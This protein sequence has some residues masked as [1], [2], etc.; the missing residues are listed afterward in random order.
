MY[1]HSSDE[2]HIPPAGRASSRPTTPSS[3]S[4]ET[5]PSQTY[6]YPKPNPKALCTTLLDKDSYVPVYVQKTVKD[7]IS[8]TEPNSDQIAHIAD[9]QPDVNNSSNSTDSTVN[10]KSEK[11]FTETS[12][13]KNEDNDDNDQSDCIENDDDDDNDDNDDDDDDEKSFEYTY[14]D[15]DEAL[16]SKSDDG[17]DAKTPTNDTN[18][19]VSESHYM[20]MTPKKSI[21]SMSESNIFASSKL[22]MTDNDNAYVEM[23]FHSSMLAHDSKSSYELVC[24]GK[25]SNHCRTESEP[26]YMELSH[27]KNSTLSLNTEE[28]IANPKQ[29][30]KVGNKK[31][32]DKKNDSANTDNLPD[33]LKLTKNVTLS[34]SSDTEDENP[35][36]MYNV[37]LRSR[38][39]FSLSDT[40]RPASYYLGVTRPDSSDSDIVSPPPI[41]SSPP[42]MEELNTEEIFSSEN[43]DTIRR[44]GK[45]SLNL[46]Y[47]QIPRI[48]SSNSS[49]NSIKKDGIKTSRLS[50]PE[51]Y[52][53][54]KIKK[55]DD[56]SSNYN[57]DNSSPTSS[58]YDLYNKLKLQSPSFSGSLYPS[59]VSSPL[60]FDGM[61]SMDEQ[62]MKRR[63]ISEDSMSEIESDRF[64]QDIP[65]ID[66]NAYLNN[67][68]SSNYADK[69]IDGQWTSDSILN[70]VPFIKPPEVF[71]SDNDK[72]FYDN[73]NFL[74]NDDC[75]LNNEQR[76][77]AADIEHKFD[78]GSIN[79]NPKTASTSK[80]YKNQALT[81]SHPRTASMD[82][83]M[84]QS[85][86][87]SYGS[88]SDNN[89]SCTS[90]D[91]S[92][93]SPVH[94]RVSS[95]ISELSAQSAP[96]YYK[97]VHPIENSPLANNGGA[98]GS[99]LSLSYATSNKTPKLNNMREVGLK[100]NGIS[101]IHNQLD[102]T[103]A[104]ASISEDILNVANKNQLIDSKN[105]YG[106]DI[107]IEK[108]VSKELTTGYVSNKLYGRSEGV[109][110]NKMMG[111]K[112]INNVTPPKTNN[113]TNQ[114]NSERNGTN[115]YSNLSIESRMNRSNQIAGESLNE[116]SDGNSLWEEDEIWRERLRHVSHRHARSLD[117]L[118]KIDKDCSVNTGK[119]STEKTQM[120]ANT[121]LVVATANNTTYD[122]NDVYVQLAKD[123]N[124]DLYERLRDDNV[125]K[126]VEINR[127]TLRQWDSMSS[128]LM[129]SAT[130]SN[131]G[132][133]LQSKT[134]TSNVDSEDSGSTSGNKLGRT[135][136]KSYHIV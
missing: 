117:D 23:G 101:H 43:C 74:K 83:T 76:R 1:I 75:A 64:D 6:D 95:N 50:L 136:S 120:R 13:D 38:T 104:A 73:I 58:D 96:Y 57:T 93:L 62:R 4:E 33:I 115:T 133:G 52:L 27:L 124:S 55:T 102:G 106:K 44:K 68:Q 26:V 14:G 53:K 122:E 66:L 36:D 113:T 131:I 15:L 29:S 114:C 129:K 54:Y 37:D 20:P 80:A 40:F 126:S 108:N 21:L 118:D 121:G 85:S 119:C 10:V 90:F 48:H 25:K 35:S 132:V 134:K 24:I 63:P 5:V 81:Y 30:K 67:L 92:L 9:D 130:G 65:D 22:S 2:P 98:H 103:I 39:R 127:E 107:K 17:D 34:E 45:S 112:V 91:I 89:A 82:S 84:S 105:L 8:G 128:G 135:H 49:L 71:R 86:K 3:S 19:D 12:I 79:D 87:R 51:Q 110:A 116:S 99:N 123:S 41:P 125:R 56:S 11:S 7:S 28:P 100:R 97:D 77:K 31:S 42:P 109:K 16:E 111:N 94:S 46:S 32:S 70:D 88:R 72:I 60:R 59:N 69:Q 61:D 78:L 18:E 47:D